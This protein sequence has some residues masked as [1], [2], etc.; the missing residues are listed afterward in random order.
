MRRAEANDVSEGVFRAFQ[1]HKSIGLDGAGAEPD[2][3]RLAADPRTAAAACAH[4]DLGEA[5]GAGD[6]LPVLCA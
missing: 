6:A 1:L 3:H 2:P 4:A 5:D